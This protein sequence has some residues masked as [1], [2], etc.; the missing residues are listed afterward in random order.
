MTIA[1]SLSEDFEIESYSGLQTFLTSHLQ[2]DADTIANLPSLIRLA[3]YRLSRLITT[4][5]RESTETLTTTIG[6]QTMNLPTDFVQL[7]Q[8][9]LNGDTGYPLEQVS[10]N[11]VESADHA[12]KPTM[13]AMSNGQVFLGPVPDAAYS[14]RCVYTQSLTPLSN[15]SPTN[16]LLVAHADAYVY[17]TAAVIELHLENTPSASLYNQ[18]AEGVLDEIAAQGNRYRWSGPMRIRSPGQVV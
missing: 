2:L 11:V 18:L 3:E 9:R 8:L 5:D 12:G 10:L 15:D 6:Q 13:F 16:W 1:L 14:I 17:M 7:R 4:L